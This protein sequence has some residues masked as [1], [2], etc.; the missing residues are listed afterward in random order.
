[1]ETANRSILFKAGDTGAPVALTALRVGLGIVMVVH[2]WTKLMDVPAWTSSVRE[3]G[4]PWPEFTAWLG[5][6]GELL[7]GAG[8]LV[9]LMTPVAGFGVLCVM[10]TA[11]FSVHIGHGLLAQNNGF[12][13]PMLIALVAA[14]LMA[15]GAGPYSIDAMIVRWMARRREVR[16]PMRA[17]GHVPA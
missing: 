5:I 9:G 4:L 14:F 13:F 6:A 16:P 2:G 15:R 8:L 1:M 10:L 11:I 12:E 3:L 17:P 7:G